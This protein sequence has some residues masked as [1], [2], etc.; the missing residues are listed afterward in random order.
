MVLY[1]KEFIDYNMAQCAEI[2]KFRWAL[3]IELQHDPLD[4]Y[5]MNQIC[6]MWISLHA[7]E[8]REY[9]E[10]SKHWQYIKDIPSGIN[11]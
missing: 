1:G 2:I 9:W 4:D 8:F 11:H 7:K 6:E 5:S 3:E 10:E